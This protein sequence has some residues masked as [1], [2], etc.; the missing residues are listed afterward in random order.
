MNKRRENLRWFQYSL[1]SL[2]LLT[3]VACVAMSWVAVRLQGVRCEKEAVEEINKLRGFVWYDYELTEDDK[4]VPVVVQHQGGFLRGL[5]GDDFFAKVVRVRLR[6]GLIADPDLRHLG[7]V[8]YLRTLELSGA[9][10]T[11]AGLQHLKGLK[12][13]RRLCL[14]GTQLAETGLEDLK[15]MTQ[16]QELDLAGTHVTAALG[17]LKGMT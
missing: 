4:P 7:G 10:I 11:S 15:G 13:L 1:R 5:L 8:P 12:R 9:R 14:D 17:A 6:P 16:L 2:F 3:L